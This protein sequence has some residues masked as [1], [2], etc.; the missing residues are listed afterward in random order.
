MT[1]RPIASQR[2][3]YTHATEKV[4]QEMFSTYMVRAIPIAR[5]RSC[6]HASLTE[7]GVSRGVRAEEL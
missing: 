4:L 2:P 7:D 3:Q 1:C 6:K 5:Q